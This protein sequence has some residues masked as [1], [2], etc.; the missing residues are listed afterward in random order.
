MLETV[1]QQGQRAARHLRVLFQAT[2]EVVPSQDVGHRGLQ[3]HGACGAHLAV[4]EGRLAEA[5]AGAVDFEGDLLAA[6]AER[7]GAD[8]ARLDQVEG[9]ARTAFVK[10]D[11]VSRESAFPKACRQS[12]QFRVVQVRKEGDPV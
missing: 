9:L 3:G 10:Q 4:E 11:H 1:G 8:L 7:E 2:E 12:L 6:V 5:L